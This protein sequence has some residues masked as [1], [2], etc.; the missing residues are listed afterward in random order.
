MTIKL[1]IAKHPSA[2]AFR[3]VGLGIDWDRRPIEGIDLE[4]LLRG[5]GN[6]EEGAARRAAAEFLREL[7]AGGE[8]PA[9]QV[10]AA[11]R[12]NGI[13]ERTL[14]RAKVMVGA[15]SRKHGSGPTAPWYWY[16]PD[17]ETD[18]RGSERP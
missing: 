12:Q 4:A 9:H 1:N 15:R 5:P 10:F 18:R 17:R 16:L 7:L 8:V 6:P 3:H 13:S 2:L 11:G 14:K